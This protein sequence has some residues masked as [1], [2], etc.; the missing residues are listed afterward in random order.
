MQTEKV[1]TLSVLDKHLCQDPARQKVILADSNTSELCLSHLISEVSALSNAQIIEVE[2]GESAKTLETYASIVEALL[3]QGADR[4]TQ[5]IALG[6][7]VVCDIAGFVGGTFKRGVDT[8]LV[9]TTTL[10]MTDA[11]IGGKCGLNIGSVKNQVGLFHRAQLVCVDTA[12]LETLPGR[13]LAN[14]AVEMLKI[15]LVADEDAAE[16]MLELS[17]AEIGRNKKLIRRCIRLK[18]SIVKQDR[19]DL[20]QRRLLNFGHT[21]GHAIESLMLDNGADILHGEAVA[22]G[23]RLAVS[24]SKNLCPQSAERVRDYIARHYPVINLKDRL[25]LIFN[26]MNADKKNRNGNYRFVLLDAIGKG[27]FDVPVSREQIEA[28]LS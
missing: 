1:T 25:P 12:F 22:N 27:S 10:A 19:L 8:F 28:L 24:L 16:E 5:L 3:E 11:S 17:P 6:G 4:T 15:A 14:G 23:I 21:L 20:A 7:G 2:A 9:P 26:Y 13:Q 18:Q